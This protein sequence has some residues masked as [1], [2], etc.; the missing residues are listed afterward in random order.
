MVIPHWHKQVEHVTNLI[1]IIIAMTCV[2]T[3]L[4]K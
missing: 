4:H 1:I 2:H 3:V